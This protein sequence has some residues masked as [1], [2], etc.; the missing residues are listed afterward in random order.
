MDYNLLPSEEFKTKWIRHYL[1]AKLEFEGKSRDGVTD[2]DVETLRIKANKFSLVSLHTLGSRN[3]LTYT[4]FL[5]IIGVS[6]SVFENYF[7]K[8]MHNCFCNTR[9]C[10]IYRFPTFSGV[11]GHLYR[12]NI[13]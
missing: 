11:S 3:Y 1:E 4:T 5:Y 6:R 7:F 10:I 8:S 2:K 9:N 13:H 12:P